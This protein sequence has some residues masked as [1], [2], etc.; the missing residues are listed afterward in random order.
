[1][2]ALILLAAALALG[3]PAAS[4]KTP[5]TGAAMSFDATPLS[6]GDARALEESVRA[7]LDKVC[8]WWGPTFEGPFDIEVREGRGPS[9]AL[10]PS[11]RGRRGHMLFRTWAIDRGSATVVHEMIHVFAPNANRFLAEGLAVY[12]HELLKGVDGYP[13]FGSDLHRSAAG[14][15]GRADL[16]VLDRIALPRRLQTDEF[17]EKESYIIAGSFVRFLVEAHGMAKFRELY[18]KTPLV[19]HRRI[20]GRPG[21]WQKVYGKDLK[22]LAAD[23]RKAIGG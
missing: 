12:G 21:R 6:G 23:W 4:A 17:S 3:A 13:V 20:V 1:M 8:A 16:A 2:R 14:Y 9:M 15:A 22:M 11:W 10:L 5:C 19:P 18:A 7:A